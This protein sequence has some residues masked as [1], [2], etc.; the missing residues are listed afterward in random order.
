MTLQEILRVK[1]ST[2]H[3]I[4]PEATLDDAARTLV[5]HRVGS[6]LVCDRDLSEGEQLVGIIT[7]RDLLYCSA[8]RQCLLCE[9]KVSEVMTTELVTGNPDDPVES[10]MGVMTARRIR[11]LPVLSE[12]RLVGLISIGDVVKAQHDQLALENRFMKDYIQS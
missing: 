5:Q 4:G 3:T 7:E 10:A 1:G 6:L 9:V 12:G 11:H 2:V 8:E